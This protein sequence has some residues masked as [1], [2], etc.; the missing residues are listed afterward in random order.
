MV[1]NIQSKGESPSK[2]DSEENFKSFGEDP[3]K[4]SS[5]DPEHSKLLSQTIIDFNKVGMQHLSN[6]KIEEA[7]LMLKKLIR[8]CKNFANQDLKL[9][10]L[11]FN[12]ISCVHKKLG[13]FQT[14][15]KLL[16]KALVHAEDGHAHE[17]LALT[18][19]NLSAIYSELK[20]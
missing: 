7:K 9:I 1:I 5:I 18:Y 11:T 19:I 8:I 4:A 20:R 17:Y 12:N 3:E 10:C 15:M 6:G 13:E 14:A 16:R 2:L